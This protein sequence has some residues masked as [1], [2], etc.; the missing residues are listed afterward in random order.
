MENEF[1]VESIK[2]F[3][4]L[5][6]NKNNHVDSDHGDEDSDTG[7]IKI[8][9]KR[10]QQFSDSESDRDKN[11]KGNISIDSEDE[12]QS[13]RILNQKANT[14]KVNQNSNS[15]S[16]TRVHKSDH[17]DVNG[18]FN[19]SGKKKLQQFSDSES[20]DK[21]N[22]ESDSLSYKKYLTTKKREKC[23]I[24]IKNS[25]SSNSSADEAMKN[26]QQQL[27]MKNKKNKLKEKF[28]GLVTSRLSDSQKEKIVNSYSESES[29]K[30]IDKNANS[31]EQSDH[32]TS[33]ERIKQIIKDKSSTYKTTICD[34]DTSDEEN[35]PRAKSMPHKK[36]ERKTA[37]LTSPKPVRM[38]AKQAME[39]MKKIKSESNR[40]L[41]EKEVT[42]PYHRPKALSLKDIMSRRKPAIASDGKSLPIKMNEAQLKQYAK[43][44]EDRQKEMMELC[45]SDTDGDPEESEGQPEKY[46]E[47]NNSQIDTPKPSEN[48]DE[49]KQTQDT[50]FEDGQILSND[51]ENDFIETSA[52]MGANIQIQKMINSP[53][54]D[55]DKSHANVEYHKNK[56]L[57]NDTITSKSEK[58][59]DVENEAD[60]KS[61]DLIKVVSK[62]ADDS[63]NSNASNAEMSLVYNDSIEEPETSNVNSTS[64]SNTGA[65]IS[66]EKT[67]KDDNKDSEKDS[68]LVS[69]HYDTENTEVNTENMEVHENESKPTTTKD[70]NDM[71]FDEVSG[72]FDFSDDEVNMDEI[73]KIIENAE[74]LKDNNVTDYANSPMLVHDPYDC[75]VKPKLTGA[76]GMVIDLDGTDAVARK[77]LTGLELLKERFSYFAK[78]KT[79]EERERENEKRLKPGAQHLKLKHELEE[80]LAE[81]R[82][83]EWA[84]R[85]E[86]EKQQ[87]MEMDVIRGDE[88]E[89]EIEKIEANLDEKDETLNE[90]S[91]ESEESEEEIQ[92]IKERPRKRNP[93]IDDEAEVSDV[94]EDVQN[95]EE[96]Q[97]KQDGEAEENNDDVNDDTSEESSESEDESEVTTKKG[98]ILKAF[99]DSDEEDEVPKI[100]NKTAEETISD[101]NDVDKI[102]IESN[103][104]IINIESQAI[105]DSQDEDLQLAQRH[106]S[107]SGNLFTSQE[108][109]VQTQNNVDNSNEET[110]IGTQTFSI[111]NSTT[112][113]MAMD[114]DAHE[115]KTVVSETLPNDDPSLDAVVG[116]CSGSFTQNALD[117]QFPTTGL[118]V[119]DKLSVI[120]ETQQND[121]PN[122]DAVLNMCSGSFSQNLVPS[123]LPSESQPIG[124]EILNLCTG[125]FYDNQFVSQTNDNNTDNTSQILPTIRKNDKPVEK[126]IEDNNLKS[127]LD[128]LNDPE[129]EEPRPKK[130]FVDSNKE[131]PIA[132][133]KKKFIIDSDDETKNDMPDIKQ[134]KKIKKKK[135]EQRALQISDDED[136]ES[137]GEYENVEEKEEDYLSDVGEDPERLVE[138]D[139][140]ENEVEV[141]PQKERKMRKIGEFF[142]QEAEL[143][144]EDEWAGSGDEDEAGLDRM[145]REEGDSDTFSQRK[146]QRELGQIHM[147]DMLD[148]DKR[149]VRLIQELL[150]ED[151]DLGDG[152]RQRKFRWR[153]ADGEEEEGTVPGELADTQ[154]EE[155]ESEEQWRKQRHEREVFL[156]QMQKQDEEELNIS[157]N[158]TTIIKANLCSRTMSSLLSEA[159]KSTNEDSSA[160]TD[161]PVALEKKS[162]KDIPSPKK[163]FTVFQQSYHG[164]LLTRSGGALARLAALAAPLATS[165]DNAPTLA[166]SSK[167]NFVFA[168]LSPADP[169]PKV[170]K[171]KAETNTGTPRLVKKMKTEEKK[172]PPR[173]SLLDHLKV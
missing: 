171:R 89:D 54:D 129:F 158:R 85:L 68:Q 12:L 9:R 136:D 37:K 144:S 141:K 66:S 156:R 130:Y 112:A 78:L 98:R 133:F 22:K 4:Q 30:E 153:N 139:S 99:E 150:F 26:E 82:S 104:N 36:K 18:D 73:D 155:L 11:N 92:E 44:L 32:E 161:S 105:L 93:M 143:T 90:E 101:E 125:K 114:L 29:E 58:N 110:D 61:E 94:E 148:Q 75:N 60:I 79:P 16:D 39:N 24:M 135:L 21:E 81:Q 2:Q 146:L 152:H 103:E 109:A 38:T 168:T 13:L 119:G 25:D 70:I 111:L 116:M 45:K 128:E 159:K 51:N 172:K 154:E 10:L 121:E 137:N 1:G 33:I 131:A 76:P 106:K 27:R 115:D 86:E 77:K 67:G 3:H 88:S 15:E 5:E 134:K 14:T 17:D 35:H 113:S 169:E 72:E 47:S 157:I 65:N 127:I 165:D 91:S 42:L 102:A 83:L 6:I 108:S 173:S 55:I 147:R 80:K 50:E 140:E 151:G 28:K 43:L 41:R 124:E 118:P 40:M 31:S 46:M 84:K 62:T 170:S 74:I 122:L 163:A 162:S 20:E 100:D 123:E 64:V 87:Q 96:E 7:I 145:E 95:E 57:V 117:S 164:S 69:L 142:E 23:R 120:S 56:S 59:N 167:R 166:P 52:N 107:F 49:L 132:Q 149:E 48:N 19:E 53:Q 34:P 138:Y 97:E 63:I 8:V 126:K 71:A 160:K